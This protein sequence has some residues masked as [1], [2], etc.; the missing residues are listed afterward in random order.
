MQS[1]TFLTPYRVLMNFLFFFCFCFSLLFF[2]YRY[3][4]CQVEHFWLHPNL[5]IGI[6]VGPEINSLLMQNSPWRHGVLDLDLEKGHSTEMSTSNSGNIK[7]FIS[8]SMFTFMRSVEPWMCMSLECR[9]NSSAAYQ[10]LIVFRRVW[11]YTSSW[12]SQQ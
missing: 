3:W 9:A 6:R 5:D 10:E 12:S 7:L 8:L 4:D 11:R 2:F 1:K